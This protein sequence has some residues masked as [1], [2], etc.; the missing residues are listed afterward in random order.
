M[1]IGNLNQGR[2][3][4]YD[5][6]PANKSQNFEAGGVAPHGT[7]SRWAYTV[8]SL[9]MGVC[10]DVSTFTARNT[11]AGA[12]DKAYA[13]VQ[14]TPALGFAARLLGSRNY[15]NTVGSFKEFS[16]GCQVYLLAGDSLEGKDED[17]STGGTCE[18]REDALV[19]EFDA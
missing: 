15:G 8:P 9:R 14:Y 18:F 16:I 7:T 10:T 3:E 5:R 17:L 4:F 1:R 6:N 19:F 13:Y 2:P 12:V 11:V